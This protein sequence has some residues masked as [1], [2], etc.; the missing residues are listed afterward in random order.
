MFTSPVNGTFIFTI[1]V[2]TNYQNWGRFQ[3][4]CDSSANTI[5][6]ISHYNNDA[7]YTSTSGTVANVL[8]QGQTVWP[9]FQYNA[10]SRQ[11]LDEHVDYA[12]NQFSGVLVH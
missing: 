6:S 10:G 11:R 9:Q 8:T 12:S 7:D 1:Q 2:A 3:L 5:L 4:V